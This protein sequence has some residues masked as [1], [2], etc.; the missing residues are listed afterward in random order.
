MLAALE[1]GENSLPEDQIG[2]GQG[3]H[4]KP[5]KVRYRI[6]RRIDWLRRSHCATVTNDEVNTPQETRPQLPSTLDT[7][8]P[9]NAGRQARLEAGVRHERTLAA[10]ACMP[11]FGWGRQAALDRAT[12]ALLPWVSDAG[13]PSSTPQDYQALARWLPRAVMPQCGDNRVSNCS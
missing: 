1:L 8:S 11:S 13:P 3:H 7:G 2:N 5:G 9:L 12:P 4:L 6:T 10:V